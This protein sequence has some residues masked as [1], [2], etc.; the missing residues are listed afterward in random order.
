MAAAEITEAA[1][2]RASEAGAGSDAVQDELQQLREQHKK[3]VHYT[4]NDWIEYEQIEAPIYKAKMH[5]LEEDMECECQPNAADEDS[6]CG[7]NCLNRLLM[8]ECNVAR[9]PCG[10]KCRNRRLQKQQHARVEIFKTEKKGWGLRALEPIRKGDFIYEY[11]GE[12]FDQAV[13]RERQL[14]YA[15]EGRFH[16]YFMSLSADTVI[17]ATRKGAVSRFIN[18]SCDPNAETQKWTVG[19]VLRI[20]FF[21]IR[22]IAVNEEITFDYQYERYG[23]RDSGATEASSAKGR[24]RELNKLRDRLRPLLA[25]DGGLRNSFESTLSFMREM[26]HWRSDEVKGRDIFLDILTDTTDDDVLVGLMT[27]KILV[28]LHSWLSDMFDEHVN[29]QR[30]TLK[31]LLRLPIKTKVAIRK[32]EPTLQC[33]T[34]SVDEVSQDLAKELLRAERSEV[35]IMNGQSAEQKNL[36][37]VVAVPTRHMTTFHSAIVRDIAYQHH[38]KV[39]QL[40]S[41]TVNGQDLIITGDD[42][43]SVSSAAQQLRGLLE[44]AVRNLEELES[45]RRARAEIRNSPQAREAQSRLPGTPGASS[46]SMVAAASEPP[47]PSNLPVKFVDKHLPEFSSMSLHPD[48]DSVYSEQHNESY[49]FNRFTNETNWL[50]PVVQPLADRIQRRDNKRKLPGAAALGMDVDAKPTLSQVLAEGQQS[51]PKRV[52]TEE[53]KRKARLNKFKSEVSERVIKQL[54]AYREKKVKYGY[55][56]TSEDFKY[57]ARKLTHKIVEKELQRRG[58]DVN[59][60]VMTDGLKGKASTR[61]HIKN[62]ITDTMK[63][64]GKVFRQPAAPI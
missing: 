8:V 24:D 57:L 14:E 20:G 41:T 4:A 25:P 33:L 47:K 53:S 56:R 26:I 6:Y 27:K 28:V 63:K 61:M 36:R 16:Y 49:Y 42:A 60:L 23:R 44:Q 29:L 62:F 12:V 15:Q 7:S 22:D 37:E 45:Q 43:M 17:D 46:L 51:K 54:N 40:P 58:Q 35:Y 5:K 13:F 10:N 64:C 55:I 38:V 30:K 11:C 52:A 50:R 9:C 59:E 18:H 39:E 31:I 32:V 34:N 48:W 3:A 21:C 19:G 1:A 2:A